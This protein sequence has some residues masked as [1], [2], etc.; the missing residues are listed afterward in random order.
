MTRSSSYILSSGALPKVISEKIG[1]LKGM[2]IKAKSARGVVA[3]SIGTVAG[4]ATRFLKTMILAKFLL[5]PDQLGI[6]AIIMSVSMIS[7]ALIE[8]GVKQS[9]IQNKQG[10]RAEYL[11]VAW[12]MQV[13]RGLC[14]YGIAFILAPWIS[15][16]YGKPEL[17][18]LLR[19]AFLAIALRGFVS[20]RA[21]VLEKEYKF[22]RAVFIIQGSAILGAI[23][24]I[25]LALVM[26]NVWALVIGFVIEMA[27]LCILSF[28]LVPFLPRF[29]IDRSS[30]DELMKFARG[31]FGT[32][33]LNAI[34]IHAPTLVL[35]KVISSHQL[36]LYSLAA[37]LSYIP[38]DLYLRIICPV[39]FPAFSEKQDD[40]RALRRGLLRTTRYTAFLIVPLIA[41]MICSSRE[42][43]GVVYDSRYVAMAVP[44]AVLCLLILSRSEASI[45]A[46]M[47]MAV[48]K[49]HLQR[50]FSSVRLAIITVFIY[51][52]AVRFGPL[53]VVVVVVLSNI[54]VLLLQVIK[55]RKVFDLKLSRYMRSYIP[56]LL[57]ALPIIFTA[58]LL[59]VFRVDSPLLVLAISV[60]VLIATFTAGVF[61]LNRAKETL[62]SR[63]NLRIS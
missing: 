56:G 32:P 18:N 8:V 2:D 42:L 30:L 63:N 20:P 38:T 44:F 7:E 1:Q 61:I 34:S 10:A 48:G 9:V 36:G 29:K 3:L 26:R 45:L 16:I 58:G 55:A 4:R 41:F 59:W 27:I 57:A 35:G 40:K 17:L 39:L 14:L 62:Q 51:P 37:L 13:V 5:A 15:S 28:I 52:A 43:L 11:N 24:S 6:M 49:P 22:G 33:I 23:I 47:Y 53:G 46:G 54:S 31:I 60:L 12:W 19:V 50:R 25:G 21:H